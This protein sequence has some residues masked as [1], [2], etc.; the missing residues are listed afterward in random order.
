MIS[1]MGWSIVLGCSAILSSLAVATEP[2]VAWP[3]QWTVYGPIPSTTFGT[4]L[5][6]RPRKE[7]LLSGEKLKMIPRELVINGKPYQGRA[8][9]L[10]DGMLNLGR[11][12]NCGGDGTGAYLMTTVT[13]AADTIVQ[14]GTG[15]D[16]WMQ[17]WLDGRPIFDTLGRGHAGN[18]TTPISGRDHR[19]TIS[20]SKGEHV[21]AVAVFGYR[22]LLFAVTGPAELREHPLTFGELMAAGRRKYVPP[23][24]SI[25]VDYAAARRDFEQ[26]MALALNDGEQAAARLAIAESVWMDGQN[27]S[28]ADAAKIRAECERVLRLG[29]ATAEQKARATFGIG[30]AWLVESRP[31]RAREEF[32]KAGELTP[33]AGWKESVQLAIANAYA[34]ERDKVSASAVLK[35]LLDA[36]STEKLLIFEARSLRAAL[37]VA[38]RV[39]TDHPR[40]FFNADTWPG[41]K[42]RLEADV[43]NFGKLQRFAQGLP[44]EPVVRDW[45]EELMKAALVQRATGSAPLLVKIRK[46][47]RATIDHY[48][49]LRD[50][51]S[52]VE[53]R[54]GCAA[55]LD[56]LWNDLPSAEREGMA[57][58]LLGYAYGRHRQDVLRGAANVE[59]DPYYYAPNMHW[60]VGLAVLGPDL[61]GFDY[62]RALAVLGRGY[63]NNVVS[64]FGQRIELM[65][66]RGGVTRVE[67]NFQDL[68]TPAWTFLHCWRSAVGAIP[69]GWDFG[70]GLAPSYVLWRVVGLRP[71][72]YRHFGHAH[73][74]RKKDGWQGEQ[75][76][77][78]NLGQFMY[79]F[80]ESQPEEA[81]IAAWLRERMEQL[82]GFG[83]GSYSIY[84]YVLDV[85]RSPAPQLPNNLPLAKHY[86]ANG[87]VLMASGFDYEATRVLYS[88]G[89][90]QGEHF[91]AGHFT[92]FKKG[93][94]ALDSGTRAMG[95]W[96]D[97][98]GENYDKQSVA[99][100]TVLIRMPG[101]RMKWLTN[102]ER[103]LRANSGGQCKLP[104]F[105]RVLA[106]RSQRHFAYVATDATAT[107]H[108]DK[109]EEM[110]RQFLYLPPDHCVVFDR[111]IAKRAEYPKSWLLHTA[112][113]PVIDGREFRADQEQGRI[114]CRTLCPADATLD[115]I[116]GPGKEFWADGRN[117]PIPAHSPY[118]REMGMKDAS[119]IPENVGRWRVEVKPGAARMRDV[120]LHLIQVSDRRATA[121]VESRVEEKGE[122][123]ELSFKAGDRAHWIILE[124]TGTVGGRVRIE[125]DGK[126]LVDEDLAQT[127]G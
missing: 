9:G 65:K 36:I 109:C 70:S 33:K 105:A 29:R 125:C 55:A 92:I 101:E 28:A 80:S 76:L 97:G 10:E 102:P 79:F 94:L 60:Y 3:Q 68:P 64:S 108:A 115:K 12:L 63:D 99:H 34:A 14:I 53:T 45:G 112:N 127:R 15:A 69:G 18:G 32:A 100:N 26:A 11:E 61:T 120:F 58:D 19:L 104:A 90:G 5:Y 72:Q 122:R 121:M 89:G 107:Y 35:Q 98:S 117:W 49:L 1:R 67:Y 88:C 85:S 4:S 50:F 119:D 106:F 113:E 111:V 22:R 16:W 6:G 25:A 81:A 59:H 30:Q 116:G 75:R 20:L 91:D 87:L 123:I 40:L 84:P 44:E 51:N 95:D 47:L 118:L 46:M 21:L 41:V 31:D 56:W 8:L 42:R 103:E 23:H 57:R 38:G 78:D 7:D 82:G 66:E 110:V 13:V 71:G 77:Y 54:I 37:E 39:R 96:A 24:W 114:F 74:W 2:K 27:V 73:S 48:R 83:P 126:I 43:A 17:W 124:K 62:L 86:A 52:H 93:Y